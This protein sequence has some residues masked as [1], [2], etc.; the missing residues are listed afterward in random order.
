M[1]V[2]ANCNCGKCGM[3]VVCTYVHVD[4]F[5]ELV[6][7]FRS[8]IET[9][10]QCKYIQCYLHKCSAARNANVYYKHG[11]FVCLTYWIK[12]ACPFMLLTLFN[13]GYMCNTPW[14]YCICSTRMPQSVFNECLQCTQWHIEL[15]PINRCPMAKIHTIDTY[16]LEDALQTV[17]LRTH[18]SVI[19]IDTNM[20]MES[21][22]DKTNTYFHIWRRK[23]RKQ[24]NCWN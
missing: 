5:Q 16:N 9:F 4:C 23:K 11:Q 15:M 8:E 3:A 14:T 22:C 10:T 19:Q 20:Q 17:E 21:R 6:N 12:I 13:A 2:C 18:F 7:G 1:H 24:A